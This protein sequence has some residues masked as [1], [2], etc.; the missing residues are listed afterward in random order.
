MEGCAPW[1]K[2][3]AR[4]MPQW[5]LYD[6]K[7]DSVE[8]LKYTIE[9]FNVEE[10]RYLVIGSFRRDENGV[11][12]LSAYLEISLAGSSPNCNTAVLS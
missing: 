1:N 3:V 7:V 11:K 12:I 4:P 9:N 2:L 6:I 10:Y 8:E 5:K